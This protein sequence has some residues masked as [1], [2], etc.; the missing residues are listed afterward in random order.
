MCIRDSFKRLVDVGL[1]NGVDACDP[2]LYAEEPRLVSR[3][4]RGDGAV[5][6]KYVRLEALEPEVLCEAPNTCETTVTPLEHHSTDVMKDGTTTNT[7][8]EDRSV[9]RTPGDCADLCPHLASG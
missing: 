8:H 1:P 6:A 7:R 2:A 9:A 3:E 4:T 5:V